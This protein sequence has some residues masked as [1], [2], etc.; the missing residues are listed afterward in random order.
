MRQLL[1]LVFITALTLF[2]PQTFA[3]QLTTTDQ[4]VQESVR[5]ININDASVKELSSL[6]G[7]G[8]KKAQ[9]IIDYRKTYGKF[10]SIDDLLNVKGIGEIVLSDNLQYLKI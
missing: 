3:N 9:A 2:V 4:V 5:S 6:K 10:T 7:I 1:P 8:S